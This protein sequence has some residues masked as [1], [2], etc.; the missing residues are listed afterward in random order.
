MPPVQ[1]SGSVKST[2]WARSGVTL[3]EAATR[4]YRFSFSPMRSE[5]KGYVFHSGFI[6][7]SFVTASA[8]SIS[9]PVSLFFS[10]KLKGGYCPSD[11][12][13]RTPDFL[14]SAKAPVADARTVKRIART[15][16]R[17]V[18]VFLLRWAR[19]R[20]TSYGGLGQRLQVPRLAGLRAC[21][22]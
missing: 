3:C 17:W 5:S 9:K 2:A 11:A 1:Y 12:R 7:S 16:I 10:K 20:T 4:S 15:E 6:W 18:T 22:S 21:L 13:R 8:R 19:W 14:A